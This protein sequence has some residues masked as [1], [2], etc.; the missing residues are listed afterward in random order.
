[1][2][3]QTFTFAALGLATFFSASAALAGASDYEFQPVAIDINVAIKPT[4][5]VHVQIARAVLDHI[6]HRI[7]VRIQI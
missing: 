2:K 1:M 6:K 5:A 4:V 3:S 7:S